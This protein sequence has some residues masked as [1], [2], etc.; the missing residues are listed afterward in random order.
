MYSWNGIESYNPDDNLASDLLLKI[1]SDIKI[2]LINFTIRNFTKDGYVNVKE[3]HIDNPECFVRLNNDMK[4]A[5]W[6]KTP[7]QNREKYIEI[8]KVPH[9]F[10]RDGNI[11]KNIEELVEILLKI[12]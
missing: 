6:D 3:R 10:M 8:N 11:E 2:S 4:M 9:A 1:G 12:V 7:K 5:F